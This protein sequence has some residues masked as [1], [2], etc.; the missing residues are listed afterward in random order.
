MSQPVASAILDEEALAE[1]C[2]DLEDAFPGFVT[3]FLA[4]AEDALGDLGRA[5]AA[6]DLAAVAQEA[7][8]LKGTAGYLGAVRLGERLAALQ[9]AGEARDA[10]TAGKCLEA[11]R[12]ALHEVAPLLRARSA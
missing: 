12:S 7:H 2:E 1:L 9:Q 3:G 10:E 11:V 5:L 8:R 4:G 6:G